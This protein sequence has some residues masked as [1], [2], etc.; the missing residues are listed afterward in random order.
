MDKHEFKLLN[1]EIS[2]MELGYRGVDNLFEY[3]YEED[4]N[5]RPISQYKLKSISSALS[6]LGFMVF[7][8]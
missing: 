4:E 7:F 6:G 3:C 1:N 2:K 5:Q 8:W